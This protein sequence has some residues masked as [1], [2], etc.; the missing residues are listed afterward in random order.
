MRTDL[1][2]STFISMAIKTQSTNIKFSE[3]G[4]FYPG[5]LTVTSSFDFTGFVGAIPV[6]SD[7]NAL[8]DV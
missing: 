3:P 6:H 1:K 2:L 5:S 7:K 8:L 4:Y